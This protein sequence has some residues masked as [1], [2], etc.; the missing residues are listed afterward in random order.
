MGKVIKTRKKSENEGYDNVDS[1]ES[2]VFQG[3]LSLA[4]SVED[5]KQDECKNAE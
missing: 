3:R 2:E 1:N 5:V 4:P